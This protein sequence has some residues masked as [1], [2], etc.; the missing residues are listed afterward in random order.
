M[1]PQPTTLPV[2]FRAQ[3]EDGQLWI[4]A[5]FPTQAGTNDPNTFTIY[6]HVGQHG[7]GTLG[8]YHKTRR[9]RVDE[10]APLLRELRSIYETPGP[11]DCPAVK[12]RVVQRFAYQYHQQRRQ[13]LERVGA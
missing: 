12:L 5:V 7:A 6:Q 8:W 2:I 10:Y 13:S 1:A 4:T 9:A 3:K 11:G